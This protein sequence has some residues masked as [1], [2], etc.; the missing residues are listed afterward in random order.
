MNYTYRFF[1]I[2]CFIKTQVQQFFLHLKHTRHQL[3]PDG[4]GLH[5]LDVD[6]V[7]S[8]GDYFAYLCIPESETRLRQKRIATVNRS[9]LR[10]QTTE[11][12]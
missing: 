3:S 8:S 6:S 12:K 10:R 1:S 4:A 11:T 2:N 9:R 5:G 7:N